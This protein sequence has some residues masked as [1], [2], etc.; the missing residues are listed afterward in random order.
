M[1]IPDLRGHGESDKPLAGHTVPNHARDLRAVLEELGVERPVLAGWSMGAMVIYEYLRAFGSDGVAGVVV[2]DQVPTDF[3]WDDGYEFG[4]FT[5]EALAEVTE[6]LQTDQLALSREFAE[7][8]CHEP[9]AEKVDFLT[10][11][12]MRV[13]PAIASTIVVDQTLR[14]YRAFLPRDRRSGAGDL[15]HRQQ[16][17][18]ARRRVDR[19]ADPRRPARVHRRRARPVL[20]ARGGVQPRAR[21]VRGLAL[22]GATL[23]E[24]SRDGCL[25][26]DAAD[27]LAHVRERFVIPDELTYLDGNSLGAMPAAVMPAMAT[28]LAA[29]VGPGA[30]PQLAGRRLDRRAAARR[31]EDRAAHRRRAGRGRRRRQHVGEP[32]QAAVRRARAPGRRGAWC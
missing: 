7:L 26:L 29:G 20:R 10:E 11:V 6:R 28:L 8:M 25:A 19:L 30:D 9:T 5:L 4:L 21:R 22:M 17:H 15:R 32:V 1:V 23:E 13:P 3:A 12:M 14:D 2:V 16:A 24:L 27:P 18:A 31:G